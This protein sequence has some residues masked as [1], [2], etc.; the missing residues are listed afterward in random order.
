MQRLGNLAT[1]A[2]GLSVQIVAS[3]FIGL[4]PPLFPALAPQPWLP[5]VVMATWA[6]GGG[7]TMFGVSP[8][9]V[10]IVES[11]SGLLREQ[12]DA[13][14]AGLMLVSGSIGGFMGPY[15]A[16][17]S[18]L[19]ALRAPVTRRTRPLRRMGPR[20]ASLQLTAS[21]VH[22]CALA[23]YSTASSS[24]VS[25]LEAQPSSSPWCSASQWPA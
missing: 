23:A 5:F 19:P 3:L 8:L 4:P 20:L 7:M 2:V 14:V 12:T 25:I 10:A 22:L 11:E 24:C 15:V 1:I 21:G 17:A 9:I 6:I 18:Q 13:V 16:A